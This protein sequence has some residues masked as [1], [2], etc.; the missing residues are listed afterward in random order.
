MGYRQQGIS[1]ITLTFPIQGQYTMDAL[2]VVCQ[3]VQNLEHAEANLW[4]DCA[5]ITFTSLESNRYNYKTNG[6]ENPGFLCFSIPYSKDW[7]AQLDGNPVPVLRANTMFMGVELPPGQHEVIISYETPYFKM[8]V[9]LAFISLVIIIV[10][11]IFLR[12]VYR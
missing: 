11:I 2:E 8:G 5:G 7:S 1:S 4:S 10:R 12:R 6:K 3:P 9:T